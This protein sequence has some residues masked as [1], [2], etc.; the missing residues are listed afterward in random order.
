MS[1]AQALNTSVGPDARHGVRDLIERREYIPEYA[2][3]YGAVIHEES[4]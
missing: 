3:V 1:F 2:L 4:A